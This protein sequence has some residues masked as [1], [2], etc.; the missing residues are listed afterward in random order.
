MINDFVEVKRFLLLD[1][2]ETCGTIETNMPESELKDL[3]KDVICK[4]KKNVVCL[5]HDKGYYAF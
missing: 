1:G 4:Y 3:F 2:S 5:I